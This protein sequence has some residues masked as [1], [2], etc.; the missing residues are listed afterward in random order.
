[1]VDVDDMTAATKEKAGDNNDNNNDN[2]NNDEEEEL[3]PQQREINRLKAML[4]EK[5]SEIVDLRRGLDA[6]VSMVMELENLEQK[7][8]QEYERRLEANKTLIHE[9]G[10]RVGQES[11]HKAEAESILMYTQKKCEDQMTQIDRLNEMNKVN[12]ELLAAM[13]Q[14]EQQQQPHDPAK[15]EIHSKLEYM[16]DTNQKLI[17]E[18]AESQEVLQRARKDVSDNECL[19]LE[20]SS[21]L[22]KLAS[23][24]NEADELM[25]NVKTN[26]Q[27]KERELKK[28]QERVAFLEK[29]LVEND[30]DAT[31]NDNTTGTALLLK[32]LKEQDAKTEQMKKERD[33]SLAKATKFSLA[34][35]STR[36]QN[37]ILLEK[38]DSAQSS[39]SFFNKSP[40]AAVA[41][42]APSSSMASPSAASIPNKQNS[43][44][45][46]SAAVAALA[47]PKLGTPRRQS[48]GDGGV[49]DGSR[50]RNFFGRA[51]GPA[52][53]ATT[54]VPGTA[55]AAAAK[56]NGASATTAYAP[57]STQGNLAKS[58][59][60]NRNTHAN[61]QAS[62]GSSGSSSNN[63]KNGK[64]G[65]KDNKEGNPFDDDLNA[66]F[67]NPSVGKESSMDENVQ[68]GGGDVNLALTL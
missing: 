10:E 39:Y 21:Q 8:H 60:F 25:A 40:N 1:M 48:S 11:K 27:E 24:L 47:T 15:W 9:L 54:P 35:A 20:L 2:N 31:D 64:N 63:K 22:D 4:A 42:A 65:D 6:Q 12:T 34:L 33:A 67:A 5:D 52:A 55:A 23:Q 7:E 59:L 68:G 36:E 53:A 56:S 17:L 46:S 37:D 19:C 58:R 66:S 49:F 29:A 45:S 16:V 14:D 32:Q 41:V 30:D 44:V 50:I 26:L 13:K 43:P 62:N 28:C 18:L 61:S 57:S 51:K 3:D 38:I